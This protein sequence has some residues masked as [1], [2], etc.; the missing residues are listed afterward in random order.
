MT[1]KVEVERFSLPL[2]DHSNKVLAV[3]NDAI[4]IQIWLSSGTQL[5]RRELSVNWRPQSRKP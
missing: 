3:I 5:T 1:S 4:G 2:P